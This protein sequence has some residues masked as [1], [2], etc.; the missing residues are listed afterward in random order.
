[1]ARIGADENGRWVA[2]EVAAE[3]LD[4]AGLVETEHPNDRSVIMIGPGGE[5]AILTTAECARSM[6]PADAVPAAGAAGPSDLVVLQGNL[7]AATTAAALAAARERGAR[8]VLNPSPVDPAFGDL[9]AR[10]D[11]VIVNRG[12]AADFTGNRDP[13]VAGRALLARGTGNVVVTLGDEGAVLMPRDG[14]PIAVA[15][16]RAAAV[17]TTG[18][19][20][21]FA[22]TLAAAWLLTGRLD[23]AALAV[24][25]EAAA[26][27]VTRYGTRAA[28]PTRAEMV[29][30]LS[31]H[32]IG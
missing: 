18:A 6:P 30:M 13:L 8:T 20:D 12:E 22:G 17:D 26:A 3:G 25:A 10:A 11:L 14:A 23:A 29:A 27:A 19:G 2:G 16:V 32:G 15:A 28:M 7:S 5:N 31:R 9:L 24:A 4:P 21:A 1:V